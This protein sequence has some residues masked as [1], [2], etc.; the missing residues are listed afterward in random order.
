MLLGKELEYL[1]LSTLFLEFCEFF[2]KKIR[3]ITCAATSAHRPDVLQELG[4]CV[5]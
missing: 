3:G 4:A 1:E 2:R 5:A